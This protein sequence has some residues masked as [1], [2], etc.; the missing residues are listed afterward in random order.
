MKKIDSKWN[1]VD[2]YHILFE[3]FVLNKRWAH[4]SGRSVS[5]QGATK[6]CSGIWPQR[7]QNEVSPGRKRKQSSWRRGAKYLQSSLELHPKMWGVEG[8]VVICLL[9]VK[10]E[11]DAF[12]MS[13]TFSLRNQLGSA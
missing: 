13:Q 3:S 12:L 8:R 2:Q 11:K 9:L 5:R 7:G 1:A 10:L 6:G 4:H